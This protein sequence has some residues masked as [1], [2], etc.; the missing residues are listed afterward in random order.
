MWL[1]MTERRF[2]KEVRNRISKLE[3]GAKVAC[4]DWLA[5][6]LTEMITKH[7]DAAIS[8]L[9][10]QRKANEDLEYRLEHSK[11]HVHERDIVIFELRRE[12]R[13]QNLADSLLAKIREA[14]TA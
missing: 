9:G 14:T 3:P 12:I 10:D 13:E 1:F 7:N 4:Q 11:E 2:Q 5:P 8:A 6:I